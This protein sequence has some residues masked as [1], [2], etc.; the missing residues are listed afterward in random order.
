MV[1]I[2]I[3]FKTKKNSES[4]KIAKVFFFF[5][6]FRIFA[7]SLLRRSMS[8]V[9]TAK[10]VLDFWFVELTPKQHFSTDKALDDQIRDRF[11]ATLEA[12]RQSE[13]F[14]WRET[15]EGRVAEIIVLDQFSRNIHRNT[16]RSFA[17]DPMA[18]ALAQ[19]LHGSGALAAVDAKLKAFAVMPFMHSESRLVHEQAVKVFESLGLTDFLNYELKHKAIIDRFGRY[20]HRNAVLGREST[21]EEDE[22][23]KEPGSS[24]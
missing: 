14:P 8:S 15:A 3:K 13:L 11:G 12:A 4:N 7:L 2:W 24:F 10:E 20:P 9:R 16:A 18:L 1:K 21:K 23:L 6:F 19:E 17:Q 5:F 22:F